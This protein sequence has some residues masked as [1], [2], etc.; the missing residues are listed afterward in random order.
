MTKANAEHNFK[1]ANAGADRAAAQ[2]DLEN[3]VP[4][5][6]SEIEKYVV[7]CFTFTL[8]SVIAEDEFSH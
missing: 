1:I 3:F 7:C 6:L 2:L 8:D 5:I 4:R